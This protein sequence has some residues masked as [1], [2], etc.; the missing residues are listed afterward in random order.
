LRRSRLPGT[1]A[2]ARHHRLYD[3][4]FERHWAAYVSE[5]LAV[6]ALLPRHGRGL[7]IGVGT[8][9]FAGPLGFAFGVD[10]APEVLAYARARGVT[11]TQAVAEALPFANATFE[12][13]LVVTTLCFVADPGALLS[14]AARVLR[15][16]GLIVVGLIDRESRLAREYLAH[17]AQDVL[18]RHA[19]FFTAAEV[20]RLLHEAG[21]SGLSWVQ[22]LHQPLPDIREVA[23]L[24]DGRGEGAFLV[25]RG[26]KRR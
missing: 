26:R 7:E 13:A 14:E 20:E 11:V 17:Q 4:W 9:R 16:R 2:F 19:K 1:E 24:R 3:Q 21:F 18:Y 5:L 10:P 6:R 23:P 15:P 25:V 12:H 22:T 8:G